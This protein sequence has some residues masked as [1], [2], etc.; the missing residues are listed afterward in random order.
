MKKKIQKY[1]AGEREGFS[2]VELI[3]VIAI[4]A[5][6]IGVIALAVLPNIQRSRESKDIQALDSIA[7]AANAAVA[8]CKATGSGEFN[9]GTT[10]DGVNGDAIAG[11]D[12]WS[13]IK[14]SIY[15]TVAE[16]AG[17]CESD[18]ASNSGNNFIVLKYDV[19]KKLIKVAISKT[20]GKC[21]GEACKYLDG[22][23][24]VTNGSDSASS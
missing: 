4:M 16:G 14:K 11:K 22:T 23:F 21:T 3:I 9:L 20:T 2:L 6:L 15:D 12:E 17:K 24:E 13:K 8:T 1:L 7:S 10:K 5:I 18:A 19:S